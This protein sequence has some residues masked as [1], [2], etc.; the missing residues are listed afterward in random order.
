MLNWVHVWSPSWPFCDLN[1]LLVQKGCCVTWCMGRGI[2][3][4]VHKVIS[5]HPR[6]PWQ[7]LIPQDLDVPM[8]VH[9]SIHHD[10]HTPPPMVDCTTYH[11][12]RATISII[13][14]GAGISPPP[15]LQRT[16]TQLSLWYRENRDLSLKIQ[17]FIVWGP[18]FCSS[19]PTPGSVTCAPK[20]T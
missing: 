7:Y 9:G 6:R 11:D 3:F 13:S 1:I 15:C 20:W 18:K 5:K 2:V 4:D 19:S 16:W 12:W 8:L 14:L 10:Q 17:R